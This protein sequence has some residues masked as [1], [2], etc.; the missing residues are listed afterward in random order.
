MNGATRFAIGTND[1]LPLLPLLQ[2]DRITMDRCQRIALMA[3]ALR[4]YQAAGDDRN[5]IRCLMGRGVHCD[6]V[7]A[8][9]AFSIVP[10]TALAISS[11]RD[12]RRLPTLD[13]GP[14]AI[15]AIPSGAIPPQKSPLAP[16]MLG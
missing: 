11:A 9:G 16:S 10:P 8:V 6:C 15:G 7:I 5:A 12:D 1:L 4:T 13:A 14:I 3:A 2:L